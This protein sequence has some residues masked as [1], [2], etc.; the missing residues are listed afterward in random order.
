MKKS[1]ESMASSCWSYMYVQN[2]GL[3]TSIQKIRKINIEHVHGLLLRIKNWILHHNIA[4]DSSMIRNSWLSVFL[5]NVYAF[6]IYAQFSLCLFERN[7]W[8][9]EHFPVHTVPNLITINAGHKPTSS[10]H[11]SLLKER[12]GKKYHFRHYVCLSTYFFYFNKWMNSY[13]VLKRVSQKD[14]DQNMGPIFYMLRFT[15]DV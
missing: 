12:F 10:S 4:D 11:S 5:Q 6:Q 14:F 9:K 2:L 8:T 7:K 3:R 13:E 15:D 1:L